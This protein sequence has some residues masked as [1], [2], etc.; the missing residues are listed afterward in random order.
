MRVIAFAQGKLNEWFHAAGAIEV[1]RR[2][3][4]S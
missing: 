1:L 2:Q 3:R 4:R